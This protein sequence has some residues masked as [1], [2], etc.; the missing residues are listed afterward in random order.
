[1]KADRILNSIKHSSGGESI[2]VGSASASLDSAMGQSLHSGSGKARQMIRYIARLTDKASSVL[3]GD[4]NGADEFVAA[5]ND[6][7]AD[8]KFILSVLDDEAIGFKKGGNF[9]VNQQWLQAVR[10]LVADGMEQE[11]GFT[12][13]EIEQ[14]FESSDNELSIIVMNTDAQFLKQQ[15]VKKILEGDYDFAQ[16]IFQLLG[17]PDYPQNRSI[18]AD[19][20]IEDFLSY[21]MIS[22]DEDELK[23]AILDSLLGI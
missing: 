11:S 7:R 2:K 14:Y 10:E 16:Q 23:L 9:D 22:I 12:M 15:T 17:E 3:L 18:V 21:I 20:Y 8:K 4:K 1:M 5:L 13:S 6:D 19:A